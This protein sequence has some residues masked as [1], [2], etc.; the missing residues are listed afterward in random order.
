MRYFLLIVF[1]LWSVLSGY[2]MDISDNQRFVDGLVGQVILIT[3]KEKIPYTKGFKRHV[4][5]ELY[6]IAE[7]SVGRALFF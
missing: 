5:D 7:N 6:H 4:T 3:E 2:T 1:S